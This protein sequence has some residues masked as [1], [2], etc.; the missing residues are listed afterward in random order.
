[1][2]EEGT[3]TLDGGVEGVEPG[4][5]DNA[6]GRLAIDSEAEGD[7]GAGERMDE[8]GSAVDGVYDEGWFGTKLHARLICFLAHEGDVREG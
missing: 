6:D 8:V 7:A 1:M 3:A 2:C 5:V 4:V